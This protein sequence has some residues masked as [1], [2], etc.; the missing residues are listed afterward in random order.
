MAILWTLSSTLFPRCIV[1]GIRQNCRN[2]SF[3]LGNFCTH[4]TFRASRWLH[5]LQLQL[6]AAA[7]LYC[8]FGCTSFQ[9]GILCLRT[10]SRNQ[11][12]ALLDVLEKLLHARHNI[13]YLKPAGLQ[14]SDSTFKFSRL[15]GQAGSSTRVL[16]PLNQ[17]S[18]D[19]R[20]LNLPGGALKLSRCLRWKTRSHQSL[21]RLTEFCSTW[22]LSGRPFYLGRSNRTRPLQL[23]SF[24]R[25]SRFSGCGSVLHWPCRRAC[26]LRTG[27]L[28]PLSAR[29]HVDGRLAYGTLLVADE[30]PVHI[31]V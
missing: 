5:V 14:A 8:S 26:C 30:V 21:L 2:T 11:R 3:F 17:A 4:D 15:R 13:L 24:I 19:P 23:R 31:A 18:G 6:P 10:G 16:N 27:A 25:R 20:Q 9:G 12:L 7:N 22:Q 1:E 28:A 29:H